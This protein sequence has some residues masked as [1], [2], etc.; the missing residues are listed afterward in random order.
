MQHAILGISPSNP[1]TQEHPVGGRVIFGFFLFVCLFVSQLEYIFHLTNGFMECVNC[2]CAIATSAVI[3]V[4][5]AAVAFRKTALFEAID[6]IEE[7]IDTSKTR[8]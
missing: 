8:W 2:I 4:C 7:L 5:F 1:S 6:K 3:F